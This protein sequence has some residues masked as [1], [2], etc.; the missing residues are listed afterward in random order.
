MRRKKT[1]LTH[2]HTVSE[3]MEILNLV[4]FVDCL[5]KARLMC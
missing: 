3:T 1:K 4:I 5:M 2:G